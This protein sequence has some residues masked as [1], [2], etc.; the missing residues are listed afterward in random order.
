MF[1]RHIHMKA[2]ALRGDCRD[3]CFGSSKLQHYSSCHVLALLAPAS[4]QIMFMLHVK[5]LLLLALPHK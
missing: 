5:T 1:I 4:S 3:F 2:L